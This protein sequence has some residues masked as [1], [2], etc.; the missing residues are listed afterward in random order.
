MRALARNSKT[1]PNNTSTM[2]TAAASKY[3]GSR[4]CPSNND[5]GKTLGSN[6]ATALNPYAE[7]TP[8]AIRVNMFMLL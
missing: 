3:T 7:P 8:S 5:G 1:C 4:P 6:I 2:I